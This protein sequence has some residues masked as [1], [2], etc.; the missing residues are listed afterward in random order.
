MAHGTVRLTREGLVARVTLDRPE[1]QNAFNDQM[2]E[3]LL[4]VFGA[5]RNDAAVRVV[6]LTGEGKSFCAGADL[7]WMKR[8]VDYTYEENYQDSLR[9]ARMLR[10][11]YT[12]PKPVIGRVNGAAIGGGTGVV[13]VCDIAIA[14]E[15]AVFGFSETKLG[16][17]P[18]AISP[19]LLKRM[20][21]RNL[22]EYFL[23]GERF[24]AARAAEMGLVNTAVPAGELDAAVDKNIKMILSGGAEALAVSK[25][26]IREVGERSLEEA[27]PYTAEVISKLRM[28]DEGQEGMN[29][30]LEK[31]KPKWTGEG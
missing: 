14:S 1:V 11:L 5:L 3:D 17:T 13:A 4:E 21:E 24:G 16:L 19:Y 10:E 6:V 29:A 12:C 2:L 20:G 30:F 27:G 28:S 22:R 26:L 9:L 31:R 25:E 23:T 8:V 15:N 7:H 18:A